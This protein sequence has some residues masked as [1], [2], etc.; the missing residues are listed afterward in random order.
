MSFGST[1]FLHSV[2]CPVQLCSALT[3][4]GRGSTVTFGKGTSLWVTSSC[5]VSLHTLQ[6]GRK[7]RQSCSRRFPRTPSENT[8]GCANLCY[9]DRAP[10]ACSEHGAASSAALCSP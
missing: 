9:W 2:G 3:A 10:G 6:G 7:S 8:T 5:P 1:R 4:Q